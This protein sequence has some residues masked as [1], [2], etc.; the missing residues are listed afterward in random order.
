METKSLSPQV[1]QALQR[2]AADEL[3]ASQVYHYA[4]SCCRDWGLPNLTAFFANE[5]KQEQE[6]Y[7]KVLD[8]MADWNVPFVPNTITPLPEF[9]DVTAVLDYAYTLE[10]TLL[11]AYSEFSRLVFSEDMATFTFIQEYIKIQ[12]QSVIEYNDLIKRWE[13]CRNLG[14]VYFDTLIE[15]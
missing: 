15:G 14:Q 6:H 12:T 11:E 4:S 2:R 1:S 13:G 9:A 3:F 5:A 8:Y 7:R 10:L